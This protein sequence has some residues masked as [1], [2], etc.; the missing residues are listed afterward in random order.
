M[1]NEQISD[2]KRKAE[3]GDATAQ[4]NLGVLY[5]TRSGVEE[6]DIQA[7][8]WYEKAAA[9]G[10]AEAQFHL[11]LLYQFDKG[12]PHDSV[13]AAQWYEKAA[14]QG[15]AEAQ[16]RLGQLYEIG[17]DN[18]QQDGTQAV[19]WLEQ[20]AAQGHAEALGTLGH[21]Y[22]DGENGVPQDY[23]RA[24]I[25]YSLAAAIWTDD[26]Q[27]SEVSEGRGGRQAGAVYARDESARRMTPALVV[28]A[29]RLAQQ[30]Q[31]RIDGRRAETRSKTS[32]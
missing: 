29:Q 1:S 32:R 27:F 2:L 23:M 3:Q 13:T 14:V 7:A 22:F 31:A 4:Y 16:F 28:E 15:H 20:A 17:F 10:H 21:M 5:E 30:C 19:K 6:D 24:Y 9:Q 18:V 25:W 8:Q 11:G 12:V 26:A